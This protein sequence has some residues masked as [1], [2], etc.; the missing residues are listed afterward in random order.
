M[1]DTIWLFAHRMRFSVRS[2]PHMIIIIIIN[3]RFVAPIVRSIRSGQTVKITSFQS[4]RSMIRMNNKAKC[5]IMVYIFFGLIQ[6]NHVIKII[7]NSAA[8]VMGIQNEIHSNEIMHWT[9]CSSHHRLWIIIYALISLWNRIFCRIAENDIHNK[10]WI[11]YKMK[12]FIP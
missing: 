1:A 7:R 5:K 10:I 9:W 2:R 11:V 4:S 6:F 12:I 3:E 8:T